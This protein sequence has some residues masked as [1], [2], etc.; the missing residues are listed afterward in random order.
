MSSLP[1]LGA[2]LKYDHVSSLRDWIFE[3]NRALELQDFCNVSAH[4]DDQ[5]D[6]IAAYRTLLNGY[7]GDF[8]IHGPFLG[9]DIASDDPLVREV[10]IKRMLDALEKCEALGATHMVVHSPFFF[11][12]TLNNVNFSFLKTVVFNNA[13]ATLEPILARAEEIGCCLMLENVGDADP[14]LRRELVESVKSPMLRL[15]IDTG[16]AH[17]ANGQFKAPPVTDFILTANDL[18]GHVHLQDADGYADRHWH[19]GEG[20]IPWGGV[21]KTLADIDASPRLIIEAADRQERLPR[22]VARLEALDLAQ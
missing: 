15:S 9:L 10:V 14:M 19:P 2:A 22:T 3:K 8:G 18:L 12:H 6:L 5:K 16:H 21:F 1:I 7:E 4:D 13:Q 11:F 17:F 20:T